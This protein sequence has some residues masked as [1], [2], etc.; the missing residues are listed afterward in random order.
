MSDTA[1]THENRIQRLETFREVITIKL[2]NTDE[3]L[4]DIRS[5]IKWLSRLIIGALLLAVLGAFF[6]NYGL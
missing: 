4:D 5:S 6:G 3:K 2:D 1:H